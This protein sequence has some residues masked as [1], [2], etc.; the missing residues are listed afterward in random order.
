[1]GTSLIELIVS[2]A[3][4]YISGLACLVIL[5]GQLVNLVI[6]CFMSESGTGKLRSMCS[7]YSK[8]LFI[9]AFVFLIH[10]YFLIAKFEVK[11]SVVCLL[12]ILEYQLVYR[13]LIYLYIFFLVYFDSNF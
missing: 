6:A 9:G 5:A 12:T 2:H 1:M 13:M 8:I 11:G 10:L 4:L 3:L 7:R